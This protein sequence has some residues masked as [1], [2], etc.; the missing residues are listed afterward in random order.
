MIV[1]RAGAGDLA[2]AVDVWRAANT[3]R[4]RPPDDARIEQV[5]A[6]LAAPKA[7]PV[8]A[9]DGGLLVGMA[10]GEP[11]REDDGAGP[12][13]PGVCFI[14]MV[15]VAPHRWR[16]GVG[17]ALVRAVSAA[18]AEVGYDRLQLWT[19][20]ANQPA[21]ALYS[22]CGFRPSGRTM[23]LPDGEPIVQYVATTADVA[24]RVGLP[25]PE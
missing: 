10:L 7:L 20:A 12:P 11:A 1:R 24:A 5:R 21:I 2:A 3:A 6:K 17:R 18:A 16:T 23:T 19:G 13:I 14:G 9:D 15:F 4:G 25:P 22:Q 8:V